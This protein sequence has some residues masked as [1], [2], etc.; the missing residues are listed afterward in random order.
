MLVE[1]FREREGEAVIAKWELQFLLSLDSFQ[2]PQTYVKPEAASTVFELLM[3][4]AVPL[5]T[6]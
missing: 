5:E 3:M 2:Q 6:C 1:V 4:S